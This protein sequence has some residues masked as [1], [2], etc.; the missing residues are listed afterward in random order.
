MKTLVDSAAISLCNLAV[1]IDFCVYEPNLVHE[2]APNKEH[3]SLTI[4]VKEKRGLR[5]R[6]ETTQICPGTFCATVHA[7]L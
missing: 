4:L 2:N 6:K 3:S 7:N 1:S 5:A